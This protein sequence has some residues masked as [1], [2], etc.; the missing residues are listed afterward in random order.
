VNGCSVQLSGSHHIHL[1]IFDCD[2]VLVDSDR[3][4]LRIQAEALSELGLQMTY[5]QSFQDFAGLGIPKT[6]EIV[7]KRLGRRLPAQWEAGVQ[8]RVNAA[9]EK[10]LEPIPGVLE[11]LDS[12]NLD[13]CIASSGTHAKMELTLG[14]TG[15]YER[16]RGRIFSATEVDRGKPAPDLFLHAASMMGHEPSTCCVVEDSKPGILAARTAGMYALG[17]AATSAP[18]L[19]EEVANLVFSD[20]RLLPQLIHTL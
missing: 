3:I 9:F 13:T 19:L 10:E 1:V 18:Q 2:G 5:E 14:L 15:L 12:L 4:S 11:A 17:Y 8:A 20:M 16:F 7:E 6:I